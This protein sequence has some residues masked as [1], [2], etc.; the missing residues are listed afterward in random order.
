MKN[1]LQATQKVHRFSY[2]GSPNLQKSRSWKQDG[3]Q[4]R[5]NRGPFAIPFGPV[6]AHFYLQL[7]VNKIQTTDYQHFGN[8]AK[9]RLF[10]PSG[11]SAKNI[12][13]REPENEQIV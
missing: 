9:I 11:L 3:P 13:S 12:A 4:L 10:A 2:S 1:R 5:C 6:E 7:G 8:I